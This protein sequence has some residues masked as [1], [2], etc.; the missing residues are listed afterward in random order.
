MKVS[1]RL[2]KELESFRLLEKIEILE[3]RESQLEMENIL[4]RESLLYKLAERQSGVEMFCGLLF[5]RLGDKLEEYLESNYLG[6]QFEMGSER[7]KVREKMRKS[8][9]KLLVLM[10]KFFKRESE[11]Q[12]EKLEM[13]RLWVTEGLREILWEVDYLSKNIRKRKGLPKKYSE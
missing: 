13:E 11:I 2:L 12:L 9:E 5:E 6:R 10:K 8:Q 1:T 7:E 3:K 4:E